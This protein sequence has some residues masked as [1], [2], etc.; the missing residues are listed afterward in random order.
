[1]ATAPSLFGASSDL[2][3]QQRE[4][5]IQ[6]QGEAAAGRNINQQARYLQSVGASRFGDALG[7]LLG[8]QDPAEEP[9]TGTRL[10]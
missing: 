1:M 4:A 10:Q 3:Q 6:A 2:L 9:R 7:G 8:G 5:D